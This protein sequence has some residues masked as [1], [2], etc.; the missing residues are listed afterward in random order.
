MKNHKKTISL[1]VLLVLI[2]AGLYTFMAS[3][4]IDAPGVRYAMDTKADI[5]DLYAFVDP[6][7]T[8]KLVFI[9]NIQGLY[10]AG[11]SGTF[12]ANV[13]VQFKIASTTTLVEDQV[14]QCTYAN[15]TLTVTGPAAPPQTG[16]TSTLLGSS[17]PTT[18]VAISTGSTVN[19]GHNSNGT[20]IYAG[21]RDDPFFFDLAQYKHVV[22]GDTCCFRFPRGTDFFAGTNVLATV[23]EVPKS[24]LPRGI[25]NLLAVWATTS[26]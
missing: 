25:N 20:Q 16:L 22:H 18:S 5:T 12:D 26:R 10:A 13:L 7:D 6:N 14:I 23:V 17:A 19:V 21:P 9:C 11:T 1:L 24:L 3:D 4:H 15:N 2:G 8:S